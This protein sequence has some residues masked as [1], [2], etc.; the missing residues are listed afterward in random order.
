M[1]FRQIASRGRGALGLTSAWFSEATQLDVPQY[2]VFGSSE[3]YSAGEQLIEGRSKAVDIASGPEGVESACCLFGAHIGWGA[4]DAAN[5]RAGRA[6][7]LA[8]L[9]GRRRGDIGRKRFFH[10]AS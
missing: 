5:L 1:A 9:H 4:H 2:F 10:R 6:G 7:S 3:R 8:R